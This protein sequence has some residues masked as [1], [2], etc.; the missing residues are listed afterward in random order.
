[1]GLEER[2]GDGGECE[3]DRGRQRHDDGKFDHGV[4]EEGHVWAVVREMVN[5]RRRRR[6]TGVNVDIE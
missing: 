2:V 3:R 4:A 1:M 5:R 6:R